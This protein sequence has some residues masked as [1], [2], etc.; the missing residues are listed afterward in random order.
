MN[1]SRPFPELLQIPPLL[2]LRSLRARVGCL[3]LAVFFSGGIQPT[4]LAQAGE[5]KATVAPSQNAF[6]ES[7]CVKCHNEEKQKGK[8][9]V[10]NLSFSIDSLETAERWQKILNALNSGEMPPED[11]KQP[12][13]EAKLEFLDQLSGAMVVAR[14]ALADQGGIALLRRLNRREYKNTLRELLGV[15]LDVSELPAD[16]GAGNF[17]S[18][19]SSLFMSS[20]QLEQYHSLAKDALQEAFTRALAPPKRFH[21]RLETEERLEAV[22][23]SL[24]ERMDARRQYTRWTKAVEDASQL[25][26]NHGI[27]SELRGNKSTAELSRAWAK[28]PGAPSPV[29]FGFKDVTDA[30]HQGLQWWDLVPFQ[31]F[32]VVQPENKTGAFLTF[33]D[34]AVNPSINLGVP[35]WPP[36]Q[37]VVR[38]RVAATSEAPPE[39]RFLEFGKRI[40]GPYSLISTHHITGTMAQ[41]QILEIPLTLGSN[42]DERGFYLCEK[43]GVDD[44]AQGNRKYFAGKRRNGIGPEFALW[45]D[46]MEIESAPVPERVL[47]PALACLQIPLGDDAVPAGEIRGAL[48]RFTQCVFR[49][50]PASGAHLDRLLGIYAARVKAGDKHGKALRESLAVAL[51]SPRFLYLAEPSSDKTRRALAPLELATRLS[52][53]LWGAPPDAPLLEKA[54]RGELARPEVLASETERLLNDPRSADFVTAFSHQWLG[55]DRLNFFQFN[56]DLYPG[57][58]LSTK[59]AARQEIYETFGSLLR[60]NGRLGGLL[61]ADSVV[62]NA[63]LANYYGIEGVQGDEFRRVTLPAGSPRGGLLGTAAVLAMGSNGEHTSPVERG[64]WV[65]RKLL[66][67]PPP[68]APPNVPQL[69]RL[70]KKLLTTQERIRAHQEDP[71]CANCHRKIDP[72]GFGLENFDAAGLWRTEDRYTK[73]GL[74]EKK[75]II[76]PAAA[77]HNGP[78]FKDYFELRNIVAGRSEGFARGF[79]EA[80]LE[81][82]LGRP[83]GFSDEELVQ[84][85]LT[86]ARGEEFAV[87]SFI[88]ALVANKSFQTK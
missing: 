46:W 52:Y 20:D 79:T 74:G 54:R 75:W 19:A 9:R 56:G 5:G 51:A 2:K 38:I 76:D 18:N 61:K 59:K 39:R 13:R 70:E 6:F 83:C 58:D 4:A 44:D 23:R 48:E 30:E 16:G 41:P 82:G 14:K 53:F 15:T 17:D 22:T 37:Y 65:L 25:P 43:G 71:Q 29:Q 34:N 7:Y 24:R 72:I 68:P 27:V 57:F 31:A 45:V 80:L 36:G 11:E 49:G 35:H 1:P 85:I 3:L 50:A 42:M 64:A 55:L 63:L 66:H 86:R 26:Q 78:A 8:F 60:E 77:L 81:Y 62:V 10:D 67:E 12:P 28:I 32:Y 40:H 47:P 33:G 69:N 21:T 84:G 87:R 73:P 88:H